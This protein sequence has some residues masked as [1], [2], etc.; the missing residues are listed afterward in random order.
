MSKEITWSLEII[1]NKV[2]E[3]LQQALSTFFLPTVKIK[4]VYLENGNLVVEGD[5]SYFDEKG[6]YKVI[7]RND[8][9]YLVRYELLL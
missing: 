8:T 7:L 2:T 5:Y 6:K 1:R 3:I 9:L 4:K